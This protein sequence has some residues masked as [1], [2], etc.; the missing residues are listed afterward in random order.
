M[1]GYE[2]C[3][4]IRTM[5]AYRSVPIIAV[6]A[7]VAEE[8]RELCKETGMNYFLAKP[9]SLASLQEILRLALPALMPKTT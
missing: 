4:Q 1:N 3:L 5:E 2:A 6:S 8:D 9:I 7:A